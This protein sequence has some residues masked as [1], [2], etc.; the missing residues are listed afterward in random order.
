MPSWILGITSNLIINIDLSGAAKKA[1]QPDVSP[2]NFVP[3]SKI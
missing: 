1:K 2:E 3:E